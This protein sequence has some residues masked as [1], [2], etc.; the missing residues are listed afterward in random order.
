MQCKCGGR[1]LAGS[2]L[3]HGCKLFTCQ[4]CGCINVEG[5]PHWVIPGPGH[6]EQLEDMAMRIEQDNN[7]LKKFVAGEMDDYTTTLE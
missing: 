7:R 3:L 1:A 5:S 4:S 6:E 2:K